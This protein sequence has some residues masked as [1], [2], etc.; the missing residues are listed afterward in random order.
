MWQRGF[1][2]LA[3][4]GLLATAQPA[5]GWAQP[6]AEPVAGD[7]APPPPE[8]AVPSTPPS[9][10]GTPDGWTLTLSAKDETQA[11]IPPLTTA[12]SSREYVVGGTFSGDLAGPDAADPPTG[13][14][15]VGYEIGCGIDMSTSNGVSLTGT[16]GLN[17]SLGVI[18]TDVISPIPDGILPGIGGNIG[19]GVTVG[20]KPGIINVVPV[21]EKEF[22]GAAPWVMVSNFR[23]KIDGCVG[24]S[25]IR[26]YAILTHETE[27]SEA[28]LAWY[29]TT[30]VV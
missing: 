9:H 8:G 12:L 30:K 17:P 19:G 23:I 24:Q 29:G 25:F 18:G 26:S 2:V 13:V 28:V 7:A 1:T 16:A 14:L 22:T 15:E 10:T 20:L 3:I 6:A 27:M 5:Y 11:V 4:C 21:T